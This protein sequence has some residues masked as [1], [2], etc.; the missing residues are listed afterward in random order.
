MK[1][2]KGERERGGEGRGGREERN[3]IYCEKGK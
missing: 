2:V 3:L 1:K